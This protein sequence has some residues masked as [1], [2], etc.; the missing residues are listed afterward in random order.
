MIK[1]EDTYKIGR[2]GRPHGLGGEVVFNFTDD[3]FDNVGCPYL[4]CEIDGILVPF[5]IE[6]YRFKS[7]SS[8]IVKFEDVDSVEAA[9]RIVGADVYFERKYAGRGSQDEVSLDFFVGF[10]IKKPDGTVIGEIVDTDVSTDNWLFVVKRD[11]TA[12]EILIPAHEE[13]INDINQK[14]KIMEMDLPEGLLNL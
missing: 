11:G 6:E 13:F 10:T 3:I 5:F 8:A 12:E 7:D 14:N 9:R 1:K 4:I 2:I